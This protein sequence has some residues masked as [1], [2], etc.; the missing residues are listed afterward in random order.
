MT[1]QQG[2]GMSFFNKQTQMF[3]G[4][5]RSM[6]FSSRQQEDAGEQ[7]QSASR[8]LQRTINSV[9]RTEL[10]EE[11]GRL[12][13]D[14]KNYQRLLHRYNIENE[15]DLQRLVRI[16]RRFYDNEDEVKE[17][18]ENFQKAMQ[19]MEDEGLARM[20]RIRDAMMMSGIGDIPG[21]MGDDVRT[22]VD[23]GNAIKK[24]SGI[25]E[26]QMQTL[27]QDLL[28]ST[29]DI[30]NAVGFSLV[31]YK[32]VLENA[33][34]LAENMDIADPAVLNK[35]AKELTVLQ[36]ATE[37]SFDTAGKALEKLE[38]R[39]F[40]DQQRE[41]F[42][43]DFVN[44][45]EGQ[46]VDDEKIMGAVNTLSDAIS[47]YSKGNNDL[48]AQ[49]NKAIMTA[50]TLFETNYLDS[51]PFMD[52]FKKAI[53]EKDG[54]AMSQLSSQLAGIGM[55]LQDAQSAFES[56]NFDQFASDYIQSVGEVMANANETNRQALAEMYGIDTGQINKFLKSAKT[57]DETLATLHANLE[58]GAGAI[59]QASDQTK[60][61]HE[62]LTNWFSELTIF[63]TD[64][65]TIV[66]SI[67]ANPLQMYSS[68][69]LLKEGFGGLMDAGGK[70]KGGFDT[71][72]GKAGTGGL[73][74]KMGTL[75]TS[76]G[77]STGKFGTFI[78]TVGTT[79]V[80]SLVGLA[81]TIWTTVIPA[82]I[83]MAKSAWT[84]GS[85]FVGDLIGGR[86]G[87]SGRGGAGSTAA[88]T[89]DD[90]ARAG[91]A[92]RS[93]AS[94]ASTAANTADDVARAGG[95]LLKG[96]GSIAAKAAIP[97]TVAAG[98]IN[99]ATN[100]NKSEAVMET[101]GNAAGGWGGAAAGAAT[102]AALGSIVPGIG[103]AIGGAV[104]GV[105]G[106]IG[107][108][109]G[110]GWLGKKA[111]GLL[112]KINIPFFEKGTNY[113]PQDGLA[114][115]HEGEAV[116][117]KAYNPSAGG[118]SGVVPDWMESIPGLGGLLSTLE[119]GY[120][121]KKELEERR[122]DASSEPT[123]SKGD[124]VNNEDVVKAINTLTTFMKYWHQ[125]EVERERRQSRK[126]DPFRTQRNN[127]TAWEV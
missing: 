33:T 53:V 15:E 42:L 94:S 40:T 2:N 63:G 90:V 80:S 111:N 68:V 77:T 12:G 121:M 57:A 100:E 44:V 51:E 82:L 37:V 62:R 125:D 99:I 67:G 72:K 98:A 73:V 55:S 27:R 123:Q 1:Q 120:K 89:A 116:V 50:S 16:G 75:A 115:L 29:K 25:T 108:A 114:Y 113:V 126:E 96:A 85:G 13:N 21:N 97:L 46:M 52:L 103:T 104:G 109:L 34:Q 107:G 24:A 47:I 23:M 10:R 58:N 6:T 78:K 91:S 18:E 38:Q 101:A 32:D 59:G 84:K 61:W 93:A 86:R 5:F 14:L 74:G 105:L 9:S 17:M 28:Q 39:G 19:S 64:L 4:L 22:S 48:A 119:N 70:L 118:D 95:G 76:I 8:T 92:A 117:P 122:Q 49:M 106:G 54:E 71:L 112:E 36:N 102:G 83:A 124:T 3:K 110:G 30:N 81:T 41:Q 56:G 65:G 35:I 87:R 26:S 127:L 66:E 20:D 31:N 7:L 60:L 69:M 45:M 88:N 79:A 43:N 11:F